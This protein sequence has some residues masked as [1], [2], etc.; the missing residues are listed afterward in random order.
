MKHTRSITAKSAL[1]LADSLNQ[2]L[3]DSWPLMA[4]IPLAHWNLEGPDFFVLPTTFQA[5]Y[6]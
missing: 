3:A 5:Q 6:E 2:V 1:R 4:L